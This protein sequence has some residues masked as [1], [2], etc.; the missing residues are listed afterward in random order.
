[1]DKFDGSDGRDGHGRGAPAFARRPATLVSVRSIVSVVS[2]AIAACA[3]VEQP[4]GG[5]PDFDP[6]VIL[7]IVP[8]SGTA[9]PGFDDPL[10]IEFD[11]V[12]SEGSGGGLDR[13]VELSPRSEELH[14]EWHRSR[15]TVEP[16]GGWRP[17]VVYHV[18]LL[19]GI[20]DLRNNLLEEGR[21]VIFS[22][23]GPI[24]ETELE[25][26]V[27]DW[28]TGRP[29]V[30]ALVEAV[31]VRDSL[32]YVGRADSIGEFRLTALPV[33]EYVVY[34]S[35]DGNTNRR[36]ESRESFD[37]LV[38]R[39]D[40]SATGD[41]WAFVHDTLGPAIREVTPL[42]SVTFRVTFNGKLDLTAPGA[43]AVQVWILPDTVPFRVDRVW[44][45]AVYDS[46]QSA[47]AE[48]AR[49][50]ADSAA[51]A[52]TVAAPDSAAVPADTAAGLVAAPPGPPPAARDSVPPADSTAAQRLLATRP[53]LYDVWIVRVAQPLEP[54]G[55]YLVGATALNLGGA[56]R[57]SRGVLVLP[58]PP[59]ST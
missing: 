33:G 49:A 17:E 31:L 47:E 48:A 43:E 32:V 46:V 3:L 2:V 52:D 20:A 18:V 24:P 7:S 40:S 27:V 10:V 51:A 9:V 8:D 28:E 4:P 36:R 16:T 56:T 45:P 23:G 14:V 57:E 6:P 39:L 15:L 41:Y 44:T 42:D 59:D 38:V 54:G 26:I 34:A 13:L 29:G 50:A 37:S 5:P 12:I 30:N 1:M 35:I 55:R 58:A 11:E 53:A 25:G 19:P 22:T 21:T